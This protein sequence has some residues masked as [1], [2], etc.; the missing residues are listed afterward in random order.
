MERVRLV[1]QKR[2]GFG[3]GYNN[4]LRSQGFIPAIFYGGGEECIPLKVKRNEFIKVLGT[5][6]GEKVLIDLEIQDGDKRER[7]AVILKE[8]QI[9]PV[10]RDILHVD[11]YH[12]SLKKKLTTTVP[13]TV[14]GESPGV[15]MGG[16]IEHFLWEVEVRCLPSKMPHHIKADITGLTL[17]DTLHIKDLD[18]IEGVEILG[19][20]DQVVLM[21]VPPKVAEEVKET[22]PSE[23][24][25]ELIP[26]RRE[27]GKTE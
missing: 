19:D 24:E 12:I 2:D 27:E 17:G 21:I 11:F 7:R 23:K 1:A 6:A 9:H 14:V 5:E 13:I 22:L 3:K 26:R 16:I 10:R 18:S 15:K 4:R 20:P 25:P 8:K